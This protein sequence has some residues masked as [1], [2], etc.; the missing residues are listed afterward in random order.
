MRGSLPAKRRGKWRFAIHSAS[1]P[2][3]YGAP[4]HGDEAG[5]P[6]LDGLALEAM[7]ESRY[8]CLSAA[9]LYARNVGSP[10]LLGSHSLRT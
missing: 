3:R 6:G 4:A 1:W 9:V 10:P 2:L 5:A 7:L 8:D